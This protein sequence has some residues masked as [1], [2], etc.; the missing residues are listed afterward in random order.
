MEAEP[1][2]RRW[3]FAG[4]MGVHCIDLL[5]MFFGPVASVSCHIG[6]LVH[7]YARKTAR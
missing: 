2:P 6:S 1:E 3:R 7:N 5:E 4:D